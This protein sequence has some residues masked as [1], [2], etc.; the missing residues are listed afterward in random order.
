MR[1]FGLIGYPLSHSFSQKYFTEKFAREK[2]TDAVYKLFPLKSINEFESLINSN[3]DLLGLNVTIPYKEQIIPFLTELDETAKAVGAVNC[4]KVTRDER[5]GTREIFLK[6]FNTD[7]YGFSQSIKPFL[8]SHHE[9]ALI[10][11][12]GGASKAVEY[13]LR[14]IGLDTYKVSRIKKVSDAK[15]FTYAELNKNSIGSFTLIVNTTPLGMYPNVND[16]P[17]I[18]YEYLSS[19]HFLYDL[20]Y[21]P[22]ETAFIKK[23]KQAGCVTMNGLNMLHLQADKAW[24][25]FCS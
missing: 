25:I 12:T 6:G 18:P 2:I 23:G 19:R 20:V 14:H 17:P 15:Q 7:A 9:R 5:R 22:E 13:C 1:T 21:N 8:E 10:L 16:L 3:P 24:D 4:V 11:G